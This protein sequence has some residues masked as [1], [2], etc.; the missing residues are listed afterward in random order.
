M[1]APTQPYGLLAEFSDAQA[2]IDA[3]LGARAAG[4]TRMEAFSPFPLEALDAPL[5]LG[6]RR[7]AAFGIIGG[8]T[9][10]LCG[11]GVQVYAN[12]DY[13][14]NIGARPLI[15]LPAFTVVTFL[16]AVLFAAVAAVLG[17]LVQCRLPRL[18]H[19]LF[20]ASAF[21]GASN[22]RFLLC[23]LADDPRFE[24]QRT[25]AWLAERADYVTEVWP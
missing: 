9:G 11:L 8:L 13:P 20:N 14:L 6:S 24:L 10:A 1:S 18:H 12:L 22:D 19:P 4:L 3:C 23:V 16:L 7:I 21:T 2:L 17:L 5:G 15:A 25:Q